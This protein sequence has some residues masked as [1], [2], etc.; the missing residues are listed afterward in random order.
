VKL[1]RFLFLTTPGQLLLAFCLIGWIGY[2]AYSSTRAKAAQTSAPP[3]TEN[4]ADNPGTLKPID[5]LRSVGTAALNIALPDPQVEASD[6]PP[7]LPESVKQQLLALPGPLSLFPVKAQE[8]AK[9]PELPVGNSYAP[10]GRMLVC[11]LVNT[12][13]SSVEGSP[14][15]GLVTKPLVNIDES[16]I[17]RV[18]IPA[19]TEVH[20]TIQ[21]GRTRDRLMSHGSFVLVWRTRDARNGL[22]L[23]LEGTV[24]TR[25]FDSNSG[26]WGEHDGKAGIKGVV[27]D[28]TNN[29][30]LYLFASTFLSAAARGLVDTNTMTNSVTGDTYQTPKTTTKN[31]ALS[32][33]DAAVQDYA[34]QIRE[35]IQR[36]GYYVVVSAGREFLLYVRQTI[37]LRQARRA[38]SREA[39]KMAANQAPAF[40]PNMSDLQTKL[41]M[42]SQP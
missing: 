32:G 8:T 38:A 31:A 25:E 26:V 6:A 13:D 19:G 21:K 23:P 3:V 28:D 36:D 30:S 4:V 20:G 24:L 39:A 17:S 10:Y 9:A 33:V 27:I 11:E 15:V 14:L 22:E 5:A 34:N 1:A 40:L 18:I 42:L 7:P 41:N 29:A 37:D 2:T 12:L 16:G 35:H